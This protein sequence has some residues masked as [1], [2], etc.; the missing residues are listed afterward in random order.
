MKK[1]LPLLALS[2]F[3]CEEKKIEIPDL[4]V[5][6]HR[7]LVEEITGVRC[8]NCPEGSK[9]LADLQETYGKENLIVISIHEA[10]DFSAPY[11]GSYANKYDF[12]TPE[13]K[14]LA[15][16]IGVFEGAPSAAVDRFETPNAT[17]LFVVPHTEWPGLIVSEFAR[18]HELGLFMTT[19]YNETDRNLDIQVNIAP[20]KTLSG[21]LRLTVV[22]TQD[23]IIDVQ[24]DDNVIVKDYVHRHVLRDVVTRPTGDPITQSLSAGAVVSKSFQVSFPEK[25]EA[26]HCSVVAYVHRGGDPVKDVLQAVEK[27]VQ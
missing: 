11:T 22:I 17:S 12:R 5:G 3:G 10:P 26:K 16:Y 24:N 7:V 2:L 18:D 27:H 4:S 21:D 19:A 20:E 9:L 14:E 23:S 15:D 6:N 1:L 13:G 25:W 8:S